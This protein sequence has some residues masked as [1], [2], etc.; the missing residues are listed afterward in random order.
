M[1]YL[2]QSRYFL[3]HWLAAIIFFNTLYFSFT[4]LKMGGIQSQDY[5][6]LAVTTILS[7]IFYG[8]TNIYVKKSKFDFLF[9]LLIQWT[10]VI[11]S[12]IALLF[13]FKLSNYF[14][15][16]VILQLYFFGFITQVIT[17]FVIKKIWSSMSA[18]MSSTDSALF[19]SREYFS[20]EHLGLVMRKCGKSVLGFIEQDEGRLYLHIPKS[21][22]ED[23]LPLSH[24]LLEGLGVKT[25]FLPFTV[26]EFE[27]NKQLVRALSEY[28][29]ELIWYVQFNKNATLRNNILEA[30][31]TF[32]FIQ[33]STVPKLVS[34]FFSYF[35]RVIDIIISILMLILLSPLLLF[36][37]ILIR[38]DSPGPVFFK[39]QRHGLHGKIIYIL[40]FRS[41]YIHESNGLVQ[42]TVGDSRIT[43]VGK[44]IRR[45]SIDELPQFWNVLWG[46]LSLVGPRPHPIEFNEYYGPAINEY[47]V[48]HRIKPGITG[49]AQINGARGQTETI[50][51]MLKR[52]QYDLEYI[53][54]QSL[55][56]DLRILFLTP[57]AVF[58]HKGH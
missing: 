36:I 58:T 32:P 48:R 49:L 44:F 24:H 29:I 27:N 21:G 15:R 47:M 40:K 1:K 34:P 5:L 11:T 6:Y 25:I 54:T 39:Q 57:F 50:D 37:A 9:S 4:V 41:M 19:F 23:I 53:R 7:F 51:K 22:G 52:I 18:D 13:F 43:P 38:V 33:L 30:I 8:Q 12:G 28:P 20:K 55:V 31:N 45:T 2:N 16:L 10:L 26:N 42:A 14:S 46:T 56:L 17:Y 35:K 3:I